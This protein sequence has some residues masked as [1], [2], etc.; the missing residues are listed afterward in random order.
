[1]S[2]LAVKKL[3]A[4]FFQAGNRFAPGS[5]EFDSAL[6]MRGIPHEWH[7]LSGIAEMAGLAQA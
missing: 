4:T 6:L 1:M 3:D 5:I 2:P 7:E